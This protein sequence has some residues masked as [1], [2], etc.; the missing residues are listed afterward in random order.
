MRK[1]Y[2]VFVQNLERKRLLERSR[3]KWENNI[4]MDL[5]HSSGYGSTC[6]M[7]LLT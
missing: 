4:K 3:H 1:V 5:N 6:H 2:E 7:L